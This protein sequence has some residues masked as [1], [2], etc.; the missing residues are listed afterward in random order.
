MRT[1]TGFIGLA[2]G[3]VVLV[4]VGASGLSH[5]LCGTMEGPLPPSCQPTPYFV[6]GEIVE[7]A[8]IVV[9]VVALVLSFRKPEL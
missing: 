4:V 9:S 3:V 2:I 6:V 8:I 1:R 5:G 7:I